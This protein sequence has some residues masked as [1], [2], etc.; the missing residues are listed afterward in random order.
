MS[1]WKCT[2]TRLTSD[3]MRT[4][5][6]TVICRIFF[7]I[8]WSYRRVTK[9]FF[10]R[11]TWCTN[12]VTYLIWYSEKNELRQ[13]FVK[14]DKQVKL[15][16]VLMKRK[17]L[18]QLFYWTIYTLIM[19]LKLLALGQLTHVASLVELWSILCNK[20]QLIIKRVEFDKQILVSNK[21]SLSIMIVN[22][23]K[24]SSGWVRIFDDWKFS[25]TV[26]LSF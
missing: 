23:E 18:F 2:I 11:V 16:Y 3:D 26:A 6:I 9:Y 24:I 1:F 21:K 7:I 19:K 13:T 14:L 15:N 25:I 22:V 20:P 4:K 17:S 10:A 8:Q 12:N 5:R